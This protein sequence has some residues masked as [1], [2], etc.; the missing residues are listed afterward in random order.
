M[1]A[2]LPEFGFGTATFGREVQAADALALLDHAYGRGIRHFDTAAAY[3]AGRAEELVGQWL[4]T[5]GTRETL[6]LATK[7][8]PPYSAAALDQAIT[9]SLRRLG[10]PHVDLLYLHRWDTSA[11]TDEALRTLDT[12][13]RR[14]AVGALGASNITP[15][16]LETAL[17][18]QRRGDFA[19]FRWIQNNQNY[20]V[21]D[22]PA[23]FRRSCRDAGVAVVTFSPLG[24]GFLTGKHGSG[25]VAGSRFAV[26][27]A[28]QPIYFT[29]AGEARLAALRQTATR[30]GLEPTALALAW[31]AS[32]A[33]TSV[34]LLGARSTEQIDQAFTARATVPAD[35]LVELDQLQPDN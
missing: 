32:R 3:S 5:R 30:H 22:A 15:D 35:A 34:V 28:H 8:L 31:A 2:L 19:P 11:E 1:G 10:V 13:V 12:W 9:A 23:A 29:P 20:A 33:N 25:V 7:V 6:T 18:R 4:A 17:A 14:G 21:R 24:A 16:S 26:A 27:P